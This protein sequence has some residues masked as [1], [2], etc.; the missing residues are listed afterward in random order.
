MANGQQIQHVEEP[1]LP[2]TNAEI[3]KSIVVD[4]VHG[5]EALKVIAAA[6][7]DDVWEDLEEKQVVRKIDRKLMPILCVTYGVQYYD[8]AM[9]AQAALFGLRTDLELEVG[10]R[11]VFSSAIFYLGFI[12]GAYPAMMMAQ[13]WPIERVAAGITFIWGIC[14]M[15]SA[16]CKTYGEFYAQRFFLGVIEAGISPLFML[17]VGGWYKK[18]E[19]AL[20]MGAWYCCTGYISIISPI[21]NYGLGHITGGSL[22]PWQYM[23]LF[24]GGITTL[25]SVVVLFFL[26]PDPIRATGFNDRERYIAVARLRSNNAGVRNLHFKMAHVIDALTDIRFGIMFCTTFLMFFANGPNSTL[27]AIIVHSF[28]FSTLNSLLLVTPGGFLSGTVELTVCYLAYRFKN[29]RIYLFVVCVCAT[30]TSC[31]LLWQLPRHDKVGLLIAITFLPSFGGGYALLMGLQIANTAGYTKRSVTSA[32]LFVAWCLG[33][34][35]GPLLFKSKDAPV[36][37]PGFEVVVAGSAAAVGLAVLYRFVCMWE[38]RRRDRGGVAEAFE[39][40]YNDDLTDNTNKQF[41]Y[42]M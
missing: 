16:G 33:N 9:L 31:C 15:S 28:G 14:V 10:N 38:N 29:I 13:R 26:P 30:I 7:G 25:W 39:H 23:Y 1:K 17:V 42:V 6:G 32:G 22:H 2:V 8:K 4:T 34:F 35:T 21:I 18:N 12:M 37:G 20:R 19:Q 41:R 27:S 5:D 24:A 3:Q 40:A 36:Y 11:F